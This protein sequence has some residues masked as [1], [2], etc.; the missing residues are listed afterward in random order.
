MIWIA[1]HASSHPLLTRHTSLWVG[2]PWPLFVLLLG[3]HLTL[4]YHK[5][6]FTSIVPLGWGRGHHE[7]IEAL[8]IL[9]SRGLPSSVWCTRLVDS[10]SIRQLS[11]RQTKP[12][13]ERRGVTGDE[14]TQITVGHRQFNW[15][16]ENKGVDSVKPF[17]EE[18]RR[19]WR[20][21]IRGLMRKM[22]SGK[23]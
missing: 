2:S 20:G 13:R 6:W 21:D 11:R 16:C 7:R 22:G 17:R 12:R 23:R 3:Y 9:R 14:I 10:T 18:V 1:Q 5:P 8:L 4:R 15:I 19:G